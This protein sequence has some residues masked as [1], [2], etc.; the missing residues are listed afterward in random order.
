M[1]LD[2]AGVGILHHFGGGMYA[3]ETQIP[4]GVKLTQHVHSFDHM[5]ILAAGKVMVRAG[6]WIECFQA[7][8]LIE[9]KAGIAHE[10]EALT[11]AT[12]FCLHATNET[13]ADRIDEGLIA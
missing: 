8:K 5:S 10:V 9:I 6:G 3:K 1:T 4:R 2:E 11:D 13:E 7:P 12:W